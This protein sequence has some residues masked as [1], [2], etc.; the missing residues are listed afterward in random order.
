MGNE[1]GNS[2][3][4]KDGRVPILNH[5]SRRDVVYDEREGVYKCC[6]K[7]SIRYPSMEDLQLLVADTCKCRDEVAFACGSEDEWQTSKGEPACSCSNG[8]GVA[9]MAAIVAWPVV[10]LRRECHTEEID[11][12]DCT[13]C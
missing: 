1:R 13:E 10:R 9:P 7:A 6:D 2:G 11:G 3:P 4:V 12:S 5:R 8:R